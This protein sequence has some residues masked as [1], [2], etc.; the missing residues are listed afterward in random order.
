[1]NELLGALV[2]IGALLYLGAQSRKAAAIKRAQPPTEQHCLTCGHEWTDS[3][4]ALRGNSTLEIVLWVCLLWPV[5][6][7]YSIWR[8]LGQ[9]KAKVACVVCASTTVVPA[10]SPAAVAHRRQLSPAYPAS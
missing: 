10:T 2:L 6:L 5:A 9:G 4:A 3:R 8:R 1:M 7:V